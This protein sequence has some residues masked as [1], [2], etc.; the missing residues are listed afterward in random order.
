[1]RDLRRMLQEQGVAHPTC[2]FIIET[3]EESGSFDLPEYLDAL[4]DDL[5]SPDLMWPFDTGAVTTSTSG[6]PMRCGPAGRHPSVRSPEGIHS[7][8]GGG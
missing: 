6:L 8:H 1:M 5:G 4:T 7:G 3:C 2:R